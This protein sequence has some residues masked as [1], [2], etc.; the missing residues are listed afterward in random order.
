MPSIRFLVKNTL[1][2]CDAFEIE[3]NIQDSVS[4]VTLMNGPAL[5]QRT[6][7]YSG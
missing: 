3:N 2:C 4:M 6:K 5:E 1:K 7:F